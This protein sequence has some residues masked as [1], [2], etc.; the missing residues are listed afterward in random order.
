MDRLMKHTSFLTHSF[1][2][3]RAGR[4]KCGRIYS[5]SF[6]YSTQELSG[7]AVAVEELLQVD[8]ATLVI[9]KNVRTDTCPGAREFAAS[10]KARGVIEVITAYRAEDDSLVVLR[11]QRRAVVAAQVGTPSGSVAV[12]V[13]PAPAE[14]DRITDQM[15]ENLHRA[16]MNE[17]EVCGAVEQLSLCGVTAAQIAKR[18][19]M[20]RATVEAALTVVGNDAS[21]AR[22][23]AEGLTL[24]QAAA[25]AEFEGDEQAIEKLSNALRWGKSLEHTAQQLRDAAAEVAAVA[26]E[27]DRLRADGLPALDPADAPGDLRRLRLDSLVTLDGADVPEADWPKIPG[28]AVVVIQQWRYPPEFAADQQ[29]DGTEDQ[30]EDVD[31]VLVLAPVW[32]CTRPRGSTAG[33]PVRQPR[34][35]LDVRLGERC[36]DQRGRAGGFPG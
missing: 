21:R 25:F 1:T 24:E 23:E 17:R 29:D 32:I 11:G 3:Q 13:V 26:G 30:D 36:A 15:V 9:G 6:F 31:P 2:G 20:N 18:T 19:A 10:I 34:R 4:S 5:I 8:P 28:A 16:E 12:R 33:V 27:A 7:M 22:M 14:V 35:E